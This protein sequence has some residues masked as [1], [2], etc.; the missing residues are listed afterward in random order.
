MKR[1]ITILSLAAIFVLPSVTM[2]QKPDTAGSVSAKPS[3]KPKADP[4]KMKA[5]GLYKSGIALAQKGEFDSAVV[6][7]TKSLAIIKVPGAYTQR[8]FAYIELK[9]YDSAVNDF[10]EA[11]KLNPKQNAAYFGRGLS[12]YETGQYDKAKED[13]SA[14]IKKD[15]NFAMAY[16][17]LA[18]ISFLEHN[19]EQALTYYSRVAKL[20]STFK[21]VYTNMGMM[22]HNMGDIN[23]AIINYT[24]SIRIRPTASA[25]NNRGAAEMNL[26]NYQSAKADFDTAIMMKT[27]YANALDNRGRAKIELGDKEGACEDWQKAYSLGLQSSTEMIIKYC[28]QSSD[29]KKE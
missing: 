27:E 6:E 14:F 23:G 4:Q 24:K 13:L 5:L 12:L 16:N 20:D 17:Y 28:G 19:Y 2:A 8:G 7:Y 22:L 29:G 18:A 3:V 25:Y 21:D 10:S 11:L 9:K 15:S 1:L 26:H